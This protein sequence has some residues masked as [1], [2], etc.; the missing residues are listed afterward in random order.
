[1]III[2]T[3]V[4]LRMLAKIADFEVQLGLVWIIAAGCDTAIF[5]KLLDV[6]I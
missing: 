6:F 5:L 4:F 3:A 1:M 2:C